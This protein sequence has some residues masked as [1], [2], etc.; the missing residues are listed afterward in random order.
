MAR[1]YFVRTE[2]RN[3]A[4]DLEAGI[5]AR[6]HDPAWML[7]R[8]WQLGELLGEDAGSPVSLALDAEMA[9]VSAYRRRGRNVWDPFDPNGA[10]L[11]AIIEAEAQRTASAWTARLRIDTG[12]AFLHA[13]KDA[14]VEQHAQAFRDD[15]PIE[16]P[17]AALRRDDPGA[18]RLLALAVGRI[19]D[20]RQLFERL[21]TPLRDGAA[22]PAV[23][24]V[25]SADEAAVRAAA[26]AWLA[27]CD[28]SLTE[29]GASAAWQPETLDYTFSISTGAGAGATALEARG[30]RGGPIDWHAFDAQP[31]AQ[32]SGFAALPRQ[33][34]VPT[35]VRFRGMP[36]ARWWEFEDATI[37]L[38]SIDAGGSD[39]AR[40]A[41]LE[42]ALVYGND[43]FAV[44][45]RLPVG[46]LTRITSLVVADTFG[47]RLSIESANR[48]QGKQGA[49]RFSLFAL[50]ERDPNGPVGDDVSD[51]LFLAPVLGQLLTS[52]PVEDVLLL[53]DEM[54]NLSWAVERRYEGERGVAV[55]RHEVAMRSAP[56][57]NLPPRDSELRYSLGTVVP[58]Y[59]FP[60]VPVGG[61]GDT[62]LV[63]QRMTNQP[64]T[65]VPRGRLLS[66][67]GR[68]IGDEEVPREGT[69]LLRDYAMTRW[70]NGRVFVWGRKRRETGRG[71]GSSGL[72]FDVA[73]YS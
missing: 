49:S 29:G 37:D 45:L 72:R 16:P 27:W 67:G 31:V 15:Y 25:P 28:D 51:V 39:V 59:W 56:E 6:I 54:A 19:P 47:M 18:A 40:M 4:S 38:G 8:Q 48:R 50:S 58:P 13:L 14:N 71:E 69:R 11:E 12:R 3:T 20:G 55:D 26:I 23:A 2:P 53:R 9:M 70:T 36:N 17:D 61:A 63:L 41:F 46:S 35:G 73:E 42:F 5:A 66:L 21:A 32:P 10:P 52:A 65:V 43:F 7:G 30:H 57:R 68:P 44:P 62:A 60:L 33:S 34:G 22:L 1:I 24:G 64:S